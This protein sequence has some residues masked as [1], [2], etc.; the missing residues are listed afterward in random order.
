MLKYK[1]NTTGY[2]NRQTIQCRKK[3]GRIGTELLR[4]RNTGTVF[5]Q[6]G[7]IHL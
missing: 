7:I 5:R 4:Y 6:K 1:C 2:E 3:W